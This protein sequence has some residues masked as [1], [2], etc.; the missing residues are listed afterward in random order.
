[1]YGKSIGN[2]PDK[3]VFLYDAPEFGISNFG[4]TLEGL[5]TYYNIC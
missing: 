2:I 4:D 1:M 5:S 3:A